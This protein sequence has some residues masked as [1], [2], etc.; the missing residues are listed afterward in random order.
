MKPNDTYN[1]KIRYTKLENIINQILDVKDYTCCEYISLKDPYT[2]KS[3]PLLLLPE[4][5]KAAYNYAESEGILNASIPVI[6]FNFL[7]SFKNQEPLKPKDFKEITKYLKTLSSQP[8]KQ[9]IVNILDIICVHIFMNHYPETSQIVQ[10]LLG[11]E[12]KTLTVPESKPEHFIG[13]LNIWHLTHGKLT[14]IKEFCDLVLRKRKTEYGFS[15]GEVITLQVPLAINALRLV[16]QLPERFYE[17]DL[18]KPLYPFKELKPSHSSYLHR[19]IKSSLTISPILHHHKK[20]VADIEKDKTLIAR[21]GEKILYLRPYPQ[22]Y[23]SSILASKI[24]NFIGSSTHMPF[25]KGRKFYSSERMLSNGRAAS[26]K[27]DG[28]VIPILS[29]NIQDLTITGVFP[30]TGLHEEVLRY[31]DERDYRNREN[32][33]LSSKDS[34]DAYLVKIDFDNCDLSTEMKEEDYLGGM[35]ISNGYPALK[36]FYSKVKISNYLQDEGCIEEM[37]YARLK[38]ASLTPEFIRALSKKASLT[39]DDK[40]TQEQIETEVEEL[41]RRSH[42]GLKFFVSDKHAK[43]FLTNHSNIFDIFLQDS[44]TYID[45]HFNEEERDSLIKSI[46]GRIEY[47]EWSTSTLS[48][49]LV[50]VPQSDNPEITS[51][52]QKRSKRI[53][54]ESKSLQNDDP[55]SPPTPKTEKII[56]AKE[57]RIYALKKLEAKPTKL[58]QS[59]ARY[60]LYSNWL[61]LKE[62]KQLIYVVFF[63]CRSLVVN[64]ENTLAK[65]KLQIAYRA[66]FKSSEEN[67]SDN[68]IKNYVRQKCVKAII[69]CASFCSSDK[70]LLVTAKSANSLE[71][72]VGISNEVNKAVD[73]HISQ[74]NNPFRSSLLSR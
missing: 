6:I 1:T 13:L 12:S 59:L 64:R 11:T 67:L 61:S 65:L 55:S 32:F 30:G 27:L 41:T 74:L 49:N 20:I 25:L 69:N 53:N 21:Q 43:K 22:Y 58:Q 66:L 23:Q 57:I 39:P 47:I 52:S 50:P 34:K 54:V 38:L 63:A 26:R 15:F 72:A 44:T 37:L 48:S 51:S 18:S 9:V 28:Y 45:T 24:A 14:A 19:G 29:K 3:I 40:E 10:H 71:E 73:Q 16:N 17:L 62:N 2:G 35:Y 56:S 4:P 31:L 70:S 7:T 60:I 8:I 68:D 46:A 5:K 42:M 33:A 36:Q